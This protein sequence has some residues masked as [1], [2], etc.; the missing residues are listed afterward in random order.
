MIENLK[1]S[2][3]CIAEG[4]PVETIQNL[5]NPC[6]GETTHEIKCLTI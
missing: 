1:Q 5:C 2:L 3:I 4:L 6:G